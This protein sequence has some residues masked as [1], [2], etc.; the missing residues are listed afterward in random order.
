MAL[1]KVTPEQKLLVQFK[2]LRKELDRAIAEYESQVKPPDRK[3]KRVQFFD[4]ETG[5]AVR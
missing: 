1:K 3:K 5:K 2:R 4:P